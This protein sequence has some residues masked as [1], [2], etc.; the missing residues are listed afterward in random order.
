VGGNV[1]QVRD[2]VVVA[3]GENI[4]VVSHKS[5][6]VPSLVADIEAAKKASCVK[7]SAETLAREK[8]G[9]AFSSEG[10]H[11]PRR[12]QEVAWDT[13]HAWARDPQLYLSAVVR[14]KPHLAAVAHLGLGIGS[15][16]HELKEAIVTLSALLGDGRGQNGSVSLAA[17]LRSALHHCQRLLKEL[18]PEVV[19]FN[20]KSGAKAHDWA[21]AVRR[22]STHGRPS[23]S[24][25]GKPFCAPSGSDPQSA[26]FSVRSPATP[27]EVTQLRQ[28]SEFWD[29]LLRSLQEVAELQPALE[30]CRTRNLGSALGARA[31]ANAHLRK[32]A[33]ALIA[34]AKDAK[35]THAQPLFSWERSPL[36]RDYSDGQ[37]PAMRWDADDNVSKM[38]ICDP[39]RLAVSSKCE[40]SPGV[41]LEQARQI[42]A[43]SLRHCERPSAKA[44]DYRDLRSPRGVEVAEEC[45]DKGCYKSPR[46]SSSFYSPQ[47]SFHEEQPQSPLPKNRLPDPSDGPIDFKNFLA[48]RRSVAT[49]EARELGLR[50]VGGLSCHFCIQGLEC[51]LDHSTPTSPSRGP[52]DL[53]LSRSWSPQ[54][55]TS[56]LLLAAS[57]RGDKRPGPA[58]DPEHPLSAMI[59][60]C[61]TE[62][63]ASAGGHHDRR[64]R[65]PSAP[66]VQRSQPRQSY[67][68]P[69]SARN[70]QSR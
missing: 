44:Y 14:T 43:L 52:I 21:S 8:C 22:S 32:R 24:H 40:P 17:S 6:A 51:H 57:P 26:S 34:K 62:P 36:R 39:P 55:R 19:W 2:M 28:T 50:T 30:A 12:P 31:C 61:T 65:P 29:A 56:P 63:V 18:W 13:K 46:S 23:S 7:R 53:S 64:P 47:A 35:D 20:A 1:R 16:A 49:R 27:E 3:A 33:R 9:A 38:S 58:S 67:Q 60:S 59:S 4:N 70:I 68:R 5:S 11:R 48:S 10:R 66:G 25:G 45:G 42:A 41:L 37:P 54:H 15:L 69:P